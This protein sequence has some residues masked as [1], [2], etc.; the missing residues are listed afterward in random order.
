MLC[1]EA[2]CSIFRVSNSLF[3]LDRSVEKIAGV[4]L[5]ARFR[6]QNLQDPAARRVECFGSLDQVLAPAINHEIMIVAV[7]EAN[8]L[9]IGI[10][11]LPNRV[12]LQKIEWG[13]HD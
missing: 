9:V 8:L 7:P 1:F 11:S 3:A 12:R 10:D 4:K 5:H 6:R 2:K 13:S